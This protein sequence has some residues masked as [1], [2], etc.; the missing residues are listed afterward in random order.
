MQQK[1]LLELAGLFRPVLS[2]Q[3]VE[4][5]AFSDAYLSEV[6]SLIRERASFVSELWDIGSYLF[7][8]PAA[9]DEKAV[10]KQWKPETPALME[11]LS[12][13][14][15][16]LKPFNAASAETAVK[17]WLSASSLAFGQ[18]MPP[19]RLILVGAMK[20]PHLFDVMEL[21]GKEETLNRIHR[22]IQ[23]LGTPE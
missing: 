13:V 12:S 8:A 17:D 23:A 15:G 9:Y 18:V 10:R 5:S 21:L 4:E 6:I 3:G 1:P 22:A 19:L 16:S 14:L 2:S 7:Q 20:G 11:E